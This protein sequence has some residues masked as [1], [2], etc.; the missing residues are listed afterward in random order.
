M[1]G[2]KFEITLRGDIEQDTER[3]E[4]LTKRVKEK[5]I[6]NFY[7]TQRFGYEGRNIDTGFQLFK[8]DELQK[9]SDL[10]RRD[11]YLFPVFSHFFLTNI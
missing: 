8:D 4:K 6:P 1:R 10:K 5:G 3:L 7:G 9:G 11:R 2:N